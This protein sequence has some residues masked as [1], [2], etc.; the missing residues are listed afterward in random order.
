MKKWQ[1]LLLLVAAFSAQAVEIHGVKV[2]ETAQVGENMLVLNGAGTRVKVIFKGYVAALY[3]AAKKT[4]AASIL[5]DSSA[6]RV[7]M[8]F[9]REV[10][11][12]KFTAAMDEGLAENN[13]ASELTALDAQIKAFRQMIISGGAVKSGDVI[14]LDYLPSSG[15]Q[16]TLNGKSLGTVAGAQLYPA[17]LKIWLGERPVDAPLKKALL[18]K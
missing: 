9:L 13:S 5:E 15:T 10:T 11:A 1:T 3:V 4:D 16:I 14:N 6:K 12:D 2:A 18:G 7:S 8:S 17:L